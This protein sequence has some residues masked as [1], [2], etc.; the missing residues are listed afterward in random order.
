MMENENEC[1]RFFKW[2]LITR[3]P[4]PKLL[5]KQSITYLLLL[6]LLH[7][8]NDY[9]ALQLF[10]LFLCIIFHLLVVLFLLCMFLMFLSRLHLFL[11]RPYFVSLLFLVVIIIIIIILKFSCSAS[12]PHLSNCFSREASWYFWPIVCF[13]FKLFCKFI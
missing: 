2:S 3:L 5:C 12:Y 1:M 4:P 9:L 7:L 13:L 8:E 6:L 11:G 10:L